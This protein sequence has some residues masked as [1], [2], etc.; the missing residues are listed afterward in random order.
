[1]F[2]FMFEFEF[3][4]ELEFEFMFE[5]GV[6]GIVGMGVGETRFTLALF[7]VLLAASP[8]A[9]PNAAKARTIGSAIF[10][11]IPLSSPVFFKVSVT[12]VLS[13]IHQPISCW[14][15]LN[16]STRQSRSQPSRP[17]NYRGLYDRLQSPITGSSELNID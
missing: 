12:A 17:I 1:M 14:N 10:F 3:I 4:F 2:E 16:I 6:L 11:I 9:M 7:A 5:I 15:N 8:Q 13:A